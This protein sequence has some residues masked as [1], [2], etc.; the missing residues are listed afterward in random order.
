MLVLPWSFLEFGT[1]GGTLA[2]C[3]QGSVF[4]W[5]RARGGVLVGNGGALPATT[6]A[7]QAARCTAPA[8][9]S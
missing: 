2:A 4:V 7:T 6:T 8:R 5:P 3:W 1:G 9:A